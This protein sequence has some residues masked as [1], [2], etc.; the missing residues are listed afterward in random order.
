MIRLALLTLTGVFALTG[1]RQGSSNGESDTSKSPEGNG[2]RIYQVQ[3]IIRRVADN[4]DT[5]TIEHEAIPGFM[6]AMTMPF[7]LREA[8]EL[9]AFKPGDSV[10]FD[11]VVTEEDSWATD[12][13]S[14][15]RSEIEL[16]KQSRTRQRLPHSKVH[17]VNEG[18][19]MPEFQLVNSQN[20]RITNDT[21]D[22]DMLLLSF[23]FT[24][25]PVPNFCPLITRHFNTIHQA[26]Q[27]DPDLANQVR[28]LS[29]SI[30]PKYDR[31]GVLKQYKRSVVGADTP[32]EEWTFA[33]GTTEEINRL[34][35]A[36]RVYVKKDSETI[37]HGL[38]TALV[39]PEGEIRA[40]WRGNEWEPQ[41]VLKT[42]KAMASSQAR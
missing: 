38:C 4:G 10:E 29:I 31:P 39:S 24:R 6:P 22:S 40:I 20:E 41:A 5:V 34:T 12:F 16:P 21:F 36:F 27:S 7:Y 23:I 32:P 3:G 13:R 17:R 35:T 25:C 33:T 18:S 14:I 8:N 30:D 2:K 37:N 19:P 42:I 15:D 28:L 9:T 26:L 1:C 11:F